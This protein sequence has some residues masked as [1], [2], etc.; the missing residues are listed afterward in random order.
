MKATQYFK[1][2]LVFEIVE[3]FHCFYNSIIYKI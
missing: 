3:H 1:N 2:V